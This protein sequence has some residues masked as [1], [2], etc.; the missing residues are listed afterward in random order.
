MTPLPYKTRSLAHIP[1]MGYMGRLGRT[2]WI[3]LLLMTIS[4]GSNAQ[5]LEEY[6]DLAV[7]NNPEIRA[8]FTNFEAA[9]QQAPQV[10][11]LPDPTLTMS[12]F[13]QMIETRVGRQEARF[14]LMQMFPW[15][16]TLSLKKDAAN[17]MAEAA[18]QKYLDKR[19]EVFLLVKEN[20]AELYELQQMVRLERENFSIL[21]TYRKLALNKFSNAKGSMV[22]VVRID[23][24]KN[25]SATNI[26]L[27]EDRQ[28]PLQVMLNS[29]LN[30]GMNEQVAIP[31]TLPILPEIASISMD[32]LFEANPKLLKL[33]RQRESYETQQLLAKKAGYPMI[34]I[35][36]DYSIIGRRDVP[37]L[38]LNG[39][40]AIMPMLSVTLPV[41]RKKYKAA[42]KEA[43]LQG[44]ATEHEIQALKNTLY[45]EFSMA[46][47]DFQKADELRRLYQKQTK[48]TE[49]AIKLLLTGFSN[50]TSDFD[51]I[52]GMNQDLLIYR[53]GI[54]TQTKEGF[55]A[56]SKIAYLLSKAE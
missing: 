32:G 39:Q 12:A 52:L 35:G 18:F 44:Q 7:Q 40:D 14:N 17:L 2:V 24:K 5:S 37:D 30:R 29:L 6:L 15:F 31:E 43:E 55:I 19:N 20:Y 33:K 9:M 13:G 1:Q 23:I 25:E 34:G 22:D 49:Q 46:G 36:V 50:D 48:T 38:A 42:R 53:S 45:S 4:V 11:A 28:K 3:F 51:E 26:R 41:F 47:Y 10:S 21:E 8:A 16:G 56:Q 27:L 54:A